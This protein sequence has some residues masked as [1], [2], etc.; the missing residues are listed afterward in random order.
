LKTEDGDFTA[1][2]LP[3]LN[4]DF[5][6][7]ASA[8]EP[9]ENPFFTDDSFRVESP[10]NLKLPRAAVWG[11]FTGLVFFFLYFLRWSDIEDW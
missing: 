10:P 7:D 11:S 1:L 8:V 9:N 2:P 3:K 4:W 5:T 6:V